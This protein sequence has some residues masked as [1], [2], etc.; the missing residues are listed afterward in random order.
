MSAGGF[1]AI[2]AGDVKLLLVV[3]AV[4]V[5][6]LIL[7]RGAENAAA[8]VGSSTVGQLAGVVERGIEFY[9]TRRRS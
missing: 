9:Q 2:G 7:K 1:K 8:N 5:A 4:I 3:G 6:A